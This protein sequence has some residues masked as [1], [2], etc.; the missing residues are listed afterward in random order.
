MLKRLSTV[1]LCSL[2]LACGDA[3]R[4]QVAT[5]GSLFVREHA[6]TPS[7]YAPVSIPYDLTN[8]GDR[9]AFVSA[10][11]E[12]PSAWIERQVD[13]H[14]E[15]YS[16]GYC[17]A[18]LSMAPIELRGGERRAGLQVAIQDAGTFRIGVTYGED[19][20]GRR[21]VSATSAPFEVQ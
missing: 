2:V 16:G 20:S 19:T 5:E 6:D 8:R 13:G 21:T 12:R 11:G 9:T 4:V 3:A 1:A 14:W 10:C 17:I 7:G 18:V 15:Q